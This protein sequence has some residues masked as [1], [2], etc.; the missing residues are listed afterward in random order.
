DKNP[1]DSCYIH[2]A[3]WDDDLASCAKQGFVEGVYDDGEFLQVK[4]EYAAL[5]PE[6][7]HAAVINEL[8]SGADDKLFSQVAAHLYTRQYETAVREAALRVEVALKEFG[9]T[10]AYGTALVETC[11]EEN[12]T[13][14][15][16][17]LPNAH[18]LVIRSA[19]R[20]YFAYVRN[21]YAH[22]IPA[23]DMLTACRLIQRSS[24]LLCAVRGLSA[25]RSDG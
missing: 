25:M 22:N 7:A 17:G 12:G 9:Q 18:R 5:T 20:S 24:N 6:G 15:P 11:L 4:G 2:I 21:E 13:L 16:H 23:T 1:F 10:N 14:V 3:L 8:T 19:F